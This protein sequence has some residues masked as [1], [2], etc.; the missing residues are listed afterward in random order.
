MRHRLVA[1]ADQLV[2]TAAAVALAACLSFATASSVLAQVPA[3]ARDTARPQGQA[4]AP[5]LAPATSWV[6]RSALYEV[7]VRDFSASGNFQGVIRGLDRIRASGANVVW[8]MPIHPVGVEGRKGTLGSPY[9]A[10][11][12]LA[13]DSAFGTLADFRALVRAVHARGMKLILDWVPDHTAPDA[14]WVREHPDYYIRNDRGE[15]MVPR[16]PDGKLQDWTDVVQLD[17]RNPALRAAMIAAMR[18]WL[19]DQGIDGFRVD[20][21][22]YVPDLFWREATPALRSAVRRPILLLA[23]WGDLKMHR[24]GFDVTY[25]WDSY[26]RLKAVWRGAPADTFVRAEL[27]DL[28]AMPPG[29]MRIRFTTNHDETAWD[30]PPVTLFG[31]SAGARAAYVATALLPGRPLLYDGQEVESPQKLRLFER[32]SIE[33]GQPGADSARAFYRRIIEL[34]RTNLA[35]VRGEFRGVETNTPGE[36]IAYRRGEA[37][38]LVNTRNNGVRV[39]VTDT[40]VD[41]WR[42]LLTGRTQY[43]DW[44]SLPAYGAVVLAPPAPARRPMP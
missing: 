9:A 7:N 5:A 24:L 43:G 32:D 39:M 2:R 4:A 42:D 19:V 17:Y 10:R 44:V 35:F 11:D 13:I 12:Y 26:N 22:G 15:L 27:R 33:W 21:A 14:V 37:I 36:V 38:V 23:E 8:L 16:D 31:G 30:N 40:N 18:Y 1:D 29:G 3:P 41:R 34:A 6:P 25:P 28:A 20:A